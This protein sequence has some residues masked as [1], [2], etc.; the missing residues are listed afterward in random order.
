MSNVA[1]RCEIQAAWSA[2]DLQRIYPDLSPAEA[3]ARFLAV[4]GRFTAMI[5]QAGQ[6]LLRALA[7]DRRPGLI[8][9]K[10][11]G[12]GAY[13][14]L[15]VTQ[16]TYQQY[17]IAMA[18]AATG[19]A[20]SPAPRIIGEELMLYCGASDARNEGVLGDQID[21][22]TGYN[23]RDAVRGGALGV[24]CP[25]PEAFD[26]SPLATPLLVGQRE[27]LW[28]FAEPFS[29]MRLSRADLGIIGELLAGPPPRLLLDLSQSPAA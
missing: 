15:R 21:Q 28:T 29:P 6:E 22:R 13:G 9:V 1:C 24:V 7:Q 10:Y 19:A 14:L 16:D 26:A 20:K 18:G 25:I 2:E 12:A 5:E 27:L 17:R 4:A 11:I 23:V 3:Q 8:A